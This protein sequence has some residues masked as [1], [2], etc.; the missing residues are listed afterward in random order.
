MLEQRI[1]DCINRLFNT[2]TDN[3]IFIYS[4]PKV[5]STTL[6]TS[7]RISLNSMYN[8]IHIHD[9]TMLNV[10][11]GINDIK[12][13]DIL[14]YLSKTGKN[15]YVIDVYRTPV[16][17]KMSE[18][19]E[20]LSPYHFNNTDENVSKYSINRI[21]DRFN[22]LF[23]HLEKG[24]HYFEQYNIE[25]PVSFDFEKKYTI[26]I[27]N[28]IK[29]IKLRLCDSDLWSQIL[30]TIF[31][32][33]I[34]IINDYKTEDKVIGK[35]YKIFKQ[36]YKLPSNYL[37]IIKNDKYFN[38]YYNEIERNIYLEY[39]SSK[40]DKE[41]IPYTENEFEFYMNLCLE[42]QYINDIQIDHYIDNGCF[43]K[44]CSEKRKEIYIKAKSGANNFQ[45]IVHSEVINRVNNDNINKIKKKIQTLINANL[46]N[47][48]F[49]P[50]QFKINMNMNN[51]FMR[52]N[53]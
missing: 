5:G 35:L 37:E 17:R 25:N 30:S 7:L 52:Q 39:W 21:T 29:Y 34:V 18:Y 6:V 50:G 42:N 23:P 22:K 51:K 19:F 28:N 20:K 44:F 14:T 16:E 24:D 8:I 45:K 2:T 26:Q 10:L 38:F 47:K 36:Q 46:I 32:R 9:E 13:N 4:P 53:F 12:I 31:S 40:L 1:E 43:C 48:K 15:I 3:Y 27:I 49:E 33:D 41:F 11:I